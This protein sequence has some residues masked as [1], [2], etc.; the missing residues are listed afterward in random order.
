MAGT[1]RGGRQPGKS[2]PIDAEAV[3]LAALHP[4]LPVAALDG[5]AREVKLLSDYRRELVR[6]RT[7]L[8]NRLRWHLHEID[9]GLQVPSRG[10]PPVLRLRR[11][12]SAAAGRQRH[13][14]P[15]GLAVAGPLPGPDRRDQ[16]ARG[17][18]RRAGA[19]AGARAAGDPWL[20]RAQR[21]GDRGRDR[22]RAPGS[23]P[24]TPMPD[25]PAP[26]RSRS[27]P[28]T[29]AARSGSTGAATGGSTAPCT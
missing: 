7:G 4:G 16:P 23:G 2:D 20:W 10:L 13:G 22:R 29:A 9:P 3:A 8:Q 27:G 14:R 1:R 6:Q 5:P 28:A 19:A 21:R 15:A 17:R 12:D 24:R 25:S 18:A 26:R 11:P